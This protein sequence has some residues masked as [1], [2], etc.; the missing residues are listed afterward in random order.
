MALGFIK[1]S[2]FLL[3]FQLFWP[4]RW[5][6]IAIYIGAPINCAIHIAATVAEIYFMARRPGQ[7]W[8]EHDLTMDAYKATKLAV[9]LSVVGLAIDLFLFVLPIQMVMQLQMAPM[10]RFGVILLF[11][12]GGL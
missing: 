3:Y 1:L 11:G 6:R 10:K 12:T 2:F 5:L 4:V 8:F 7:S 9:P